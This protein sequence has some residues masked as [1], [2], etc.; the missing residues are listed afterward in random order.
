MS[1][2]KERRAADIALRNGVRKIM[3]RSKR[4][5]RKMWAARRTNWAFSARVRFKRHGY[6][7]KHTKFF[8][9]NFQYGYYGGIGRGI[10]AGEW[11]KPMDDLDELYLAHDKAF[12]PKDKL[13]LWESRASLR[14]QT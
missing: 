5:S 6:P 10:P 8:T 14:A 13:K 4:F 1:T 9:G 11:R 7:K 2:Y 3:K 12:A